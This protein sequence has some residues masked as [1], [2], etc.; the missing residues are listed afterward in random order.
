MRSFSS[1]RVN[2]DGNSHSH[3]KWIEDFLEIFKDPN[4]FYSLSEEEKREIYHHLIDRI[5]IRDGEVVEITENVPF[6]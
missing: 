5:I 4:Y 3:F 6:R 2:A 1:R